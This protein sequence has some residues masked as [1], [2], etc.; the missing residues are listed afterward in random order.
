MEGMK[1][2]VIASTA[3]TAIAI[4]ACG[5]TLAPTVTPSL[6]PTAGST[7]EPT[8][9]PT[10]T[11]T[12][13]P[14]ETATPEPTPTQTPTSGPPSGPPILTAL[15]APSTTE[16]AWQISSTD[17]LSNYNLDLSFT[18]GATFPM[19]E[20]S[21]TQPYTF[22]TPNA[23]DEQLVLVRWD[24]YPSFVSNGTNADST[25]CTTTPSPG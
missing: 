20:T 2:T 25:L 16:F 12:P 21:A 3:I 23:P 8:A 10:Q 11:D 19:E 4:A 5:S 17:T 7:L 9:S 13:A 18:A 22:D 1:F 24:S 6:A 14:T 15:C